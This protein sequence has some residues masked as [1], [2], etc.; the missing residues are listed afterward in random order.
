[1][2]DLYYDPSATIFLCLDP[3]WWNNFTG[4]LQP[5]LNGER[6]IVLFG[7]YQECRTNEENALI[8]FKIHQDRGYGPLMGGFCD[9]SKPEAA[10]A[11]SQTFGVEIIG[12][13]GHVE[14]G[15]RIIQ[16]WLKAAAMTKG[17]SGLVF[18][19]NCPRRLFEEWREYR[20]HEPGKGSHHSNDAIRYFFMGWLGH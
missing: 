10:R 1:M 4:W 19:R 18:S 17:E 13:G 3:G 9:P 12:A 5:S 6:I 7:H 14:D 2:S 8:C 11:Y 20:V 15:Q 16:S